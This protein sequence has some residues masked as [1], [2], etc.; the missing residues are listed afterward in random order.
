MA[1]GPTGIAVLTSY[2]LKVRIALFPFLFKT[3]YYVGIITSLSPVGDLGWL[4]SLKASIMPC[5]LKSNSVP[6][7]SAVHRP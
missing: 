6:K 5:Y 4:N 2:I 3:C 7:L 1:F